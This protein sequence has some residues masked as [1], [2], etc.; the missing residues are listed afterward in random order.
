MKEVDKMGEEKLGRMLSE[1]AD[2]SAESVR[3]GLAEEIKHHIPKPL[4][5]LKRGIHTVSIMIDLRVGKLTA[6]AAIIIAMVLFASFLGSRDSNIYQD[7]KLLA[8][9]FLGDMEKSPMQTAKSR[10]DVLVGQNKDVVFYEDVDPRDSDAVLMHWKRPN[11]NYKVVYGDLR[12]SEV[13]AD[14]LIRIQFK[15]LSRQRK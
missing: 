5:P 9:Y 14:E 6:A 4:I 8:R 11:G 3:A 2:R 10:Y 7:G 1:L 15:M 12:E 13:S